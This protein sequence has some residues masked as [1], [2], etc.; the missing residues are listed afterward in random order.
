MVPAVLE[1]KR[2]ASYRGFSLHANVSC[3][4]HE[5]EQ[6]EHMVR[7]IARSPVAIDRLHKRDDGLI[8][9]LILSQP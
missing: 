4:A 1:G 7:Y 8:T 9:I 5:R 3:K 6:L 2:C